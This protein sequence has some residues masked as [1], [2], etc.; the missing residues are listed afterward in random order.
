MRIHPG[1]SHQAQRIK[2]AR[3]LITKHVLGRTI[4]GPGDVARQTSVVKAALEM[5]ETATAPGTI[6]EFPATYPA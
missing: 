2:P 3:T 1:I 6:R 5:L 4:G